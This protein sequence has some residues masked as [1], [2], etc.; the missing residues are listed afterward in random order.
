MK[1]EKQISGRLSKLY[2]GY[3]N[4]QYTKWKILTD[5]L[6]GGVLRELKGAEGPLLDIGCGMGLSAFY[7]RESGVKRSLLGF[8]FDERKIQQARDVACRGGYE[9]VSFFSGDARDGLPEHEGSVLILDILQYFNRDDREK[10][11]LAAM[12]RLGPGGK[13]IIR[14]GLE[15]PSLRYRVTRL[16]DHF[17]RACTWMKAP[18]VRYPTVSELQVLAEDS[19]LVLKVEPFWGRTPFNNFLIVASH[20]EK[21]TPIPSRESAQGAIA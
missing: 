12:K 14:S 15:S 13:L 11:L 18:P 4:Q 9:G 10:L 2:D 16:A 19:G 6:Y 21:P 5:P 7:L 3:F 8:D 1:N 20:P 17:A